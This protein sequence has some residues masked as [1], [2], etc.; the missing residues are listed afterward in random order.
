MIGAPRGN[1]AGNDGGNSG[2]N[3]GGNA[4]GNVGGLAELLAT[5]E[6]RATE[7]D[8]IQAHA[9]VAAVLH[10]VVTELRTLNG[11]PPFPSAPA[12]AP[13]LERHLTPAEVATLLQVP[14][15]YPYRH[16]HQLGG[17]KIG[18]YLRFPE[19]AVRR[20]LERSW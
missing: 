4:G 14:A 5:L 8:R 11:T 17:V 3:S 10:D 15:A 19:S 7:A 20:R 13:G 9:P 16:R 6:R 18:K 12:Q 1:P 2:G